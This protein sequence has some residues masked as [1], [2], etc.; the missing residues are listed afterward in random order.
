MKHVIPIVSIL[1]GLTGLVG[2]TASMWLD[3]GPVCREC[4]QQCADC[5]CPG[6]CQCAP[7]DDGWK[8]ATHTKCGCLNCDCP[9]GKLGCPCTQVEVSNLPPAEFMGQQIKHAM[10][11]SG[12]QAS[13]SPDT[14]LLFFTSDF[15]GPCRQ[16]EPV[17][18]DLQRRGRSVRTINVS[19]DGYDEYQQR[20]CSGTPTLIVLRG[21]QEFKRFNG[22]PVDPAEVEKAM[23]P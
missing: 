8:P 7:A 4:Q 14:E 17:V 23:A 2:G 21:G 13:R 16:V 18:E 5:Q 1:C 20:Q 6:G 12:Q 10:P 22:A 19:H 9:G 11:T 3:A 15:C